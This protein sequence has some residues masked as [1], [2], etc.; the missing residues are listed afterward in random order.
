MCYDFTGT[1]CDTRAT[2]DNLLKIFATFSEIEQSKGEIH[3]HI[4]TLPTKRLTITEINNSNKID[5]PF[6]DNPKH[7]HSQM[8]IKNGGNDNSLSKS[9]S[10]VDMNHML[11]PPTMMMMHHHNVPAFSLTTDKLLVSSRISSQ[12]IDIQERSVLI[13]NQQQR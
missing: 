1:R 9:H 7:L 2:I 6:K 11:P 10:S 4:R 3:S 8:S 5:G 13:N 12:P